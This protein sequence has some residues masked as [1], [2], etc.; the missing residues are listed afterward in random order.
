MCAATM[1]PMAVDAA[2]DMSGSNPPTLHRAA[3]PDLLTIAAIAI[4][5]TVITDVIH[6]GLG[7]GGMWLQAG[8][9]WRFLQCTLNVARTLVWWRRAGHSPI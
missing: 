1:R 8:I 5:A 4:A 7:H 2:G 6:E 3:Q 9:R